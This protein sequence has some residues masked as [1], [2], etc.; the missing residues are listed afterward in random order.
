MTRLRAWAHVAIGLVGT[1]MA[2]DLF[3]AGIVNATHAAR[4][5]L[6]PGLVA[7]NALFAIGLTWLPIFAPLRRYRRIAAWRKETRRDRRLG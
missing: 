1:W 5:P 4:L 7:L 2:A 6:I 3:L